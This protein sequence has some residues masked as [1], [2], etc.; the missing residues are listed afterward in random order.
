MSKCLVLFHNNIVF[1]KGRAAL[2]IVESEDSP[3][4]VLLHF[5]LKFQSNLKF[6]ALG[7]W[8]SGKEKDSFI[9]KLLSHCEAFTNLLPEL[10]KL[11][12]EENILWFCSCLYSAPSLPRTRMPFVCFTGWHFAACYLP[13][14]V[15]VHASRQPGGEQNSVVSAGERR[16]R[17]PSSVGDGGGSRERESWGLN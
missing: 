13:S 6:P 5:L 9:I 11:C 17:T 14:A 2:N 4:S 12:P 15:A 3:P 16:R 10:V 1:W 7:G 8:T